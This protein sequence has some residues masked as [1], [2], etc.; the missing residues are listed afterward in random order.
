MAHQKFLKISYGP[1][2][3]DPH[4][5]PLPPSYIV[6]VAYLRYFNF[7]T[8]FFKNKN[9]LQKTAIPFFG[10]KCWD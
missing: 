9:L 4:S 3:Y 10:S 6:N 1:S 2:I 8:N 7:E 5:N